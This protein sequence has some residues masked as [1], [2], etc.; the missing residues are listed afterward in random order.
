VPRADL[1]SYR[2]IGGGLQAGPSFSFGTGRRVPVRSAPA[3][4]TRTPPGRG[5]RYLSR[6]TKDG[7]APPIEAPGPC[8]PGASGGE[9]RVAEDFTL[10]LRIRQ[11]K[12]ETI[13]EVVGPPSEWLCSIPSSAGFWG[14]SD[15]QSGEARACPAAAGRGDGWRRDG[16]RRTCA[17]SRSLTRGA[18]AFRFVRSQPAPDRLELTTLPIRGEGDELV[19]RLKGYA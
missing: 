18:S 4:R 19:D 14:V 15:A 11:R 6:S 9:G 2:R 17:W 1:G 5:H 16:R 3:R 13:R 10:A 7:Q 12:R 8:G